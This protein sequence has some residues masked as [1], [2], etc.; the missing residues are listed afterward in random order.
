MCSEG[1]LTKIIQQEVKFNCL[2]QQHTE[3]RH[4]VDQ[5]Q[6]SPVILEQSRRHYILFFVGPL[7]AKEA[8]REKT[9]KSL[10]FTFLNTRPS[11]PEPCEAL[12]SNNKSHSKLGSYLTGTHFVPIIRAS[13]L[14]VCKKISLFA[15]RVK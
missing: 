7:I 14:T 1:N 10:M 12:S 3:C 2:H 6:F 15:S 8:C 11:L 9:T 5:C 13:R 4:R